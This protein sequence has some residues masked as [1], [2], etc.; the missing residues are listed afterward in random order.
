MDAIESKGI[1]LTKMLDP[2]AEWPK[3]KNELFGLELLTVAKR[4]TEENYRQRPG[5]STL[6]LDLSQLND[7]ARQKRG[8]ETPRQEG[9]GSRG[10]SRLT[11]PAVGVSK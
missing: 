7:K 1:D 2:K 10:T 4:A 3:G 6:L 5:V 9:P 11:P 8:E